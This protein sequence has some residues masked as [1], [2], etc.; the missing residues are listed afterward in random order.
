M[1]RPEFIFK[2]SRPTFIINK[3]SAFSNKSNPSSQN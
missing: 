1:D 2:K 3:R